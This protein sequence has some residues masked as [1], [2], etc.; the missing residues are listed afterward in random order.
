[1]KTLTIQQVIEF[2]PCYNQEKIKSLFNGRK[3]VTLIEILDSNVPKSDIVWLMTRPGIMNEIQIKNFCERTAMRA[4]KNY[5]LNI[6]IPIIEEWA[7]TW[8]YKTNR[9]KSFNIKIAD[10]AGDRQRAAI[11]AAMW[12]IIGNASK[13]AIAA[14]SA[15]EY[16]GKKEAELEFQINDLREIIFE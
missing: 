1:M 10:S 14:V 11:Y 16:A 9:T 15:A 4:I 6:G 5:C 8:L 3:S 2:K 7:D 13:T 12:T